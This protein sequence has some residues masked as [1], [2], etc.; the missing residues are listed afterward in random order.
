MI[1]LFDNTEQKMQ[2]EI[3]IGLSRLP[4]TFEAIPQGNHFIVRRK[5]KKI[6][7][8]VPAAAMPHVTRILGS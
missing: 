7:M 4:E 8:K 6:G 2:D 5:G 3:R 1:T